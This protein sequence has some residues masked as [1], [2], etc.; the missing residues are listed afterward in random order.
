MRVS[1]VVSYES[2]NHTKLHCRTR[3]RK[4]PRKRVHHKL[5]L[6]AAQRAFRQHL[7][8]FAAL[9]TLLCLLFALAQALL[10]LHLEQRAGLETHV[11]HGHLLR[12]GHAARTGAQ[13]AVHAHDA[14]GPGG[15]PVGPQALH[16]G[17]LDARA[18]REHLAVEAE[19]DRE[20]GVVVLGV[21]AKGGLAAP[22]R[23][24]ARARP[25][26]LLGLDA[27]PVVQNEL[28]GDR[29]LEAQ[30]AFRAVE[31]LR[32][33]PRRRGQLQFDRARGFAD[34]QDAQG[35]RPAGPQQAPRAPSTS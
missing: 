19:L 24:R 9:C 14:G 34:P 21:G 1:R 6:L 27:L 10:E 25:H 18:A 8:T 5:P 12:F 15:Q 13:V 32:A 3:V 22:V 26:V 20:L 23:V 16:R 4:P 33:R 30:H 31:R 7:S 29:A 35:A 11:P 17:E 2:R 28:L